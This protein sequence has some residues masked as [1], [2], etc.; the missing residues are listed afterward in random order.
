MVL[1]EASVREISL[2][3]RPVY[4]ESHVCVIKAVVK[5][6]FEYLC[7]ILRDIFYLKK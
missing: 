2:F 7:V 1:G 4:I 3:Y 6:S 5:F